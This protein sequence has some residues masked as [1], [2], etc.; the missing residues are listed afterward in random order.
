MRIAD[1]S[2]DGAGCLVTQFPVLGCGGAVVAGGAERGDLP[3][4]LLHVRRPTN[5]VIAAA[6]ALFLAACGS[7]TS[8]SV[9]SPS[10][11]E[12]CQT[13]VSGPPLSFGPSGGVGAITVSAARE[14]AWAASSQAAWIVLTSAADGQGDGSLSYRVV[15]NADPVLRRGVIW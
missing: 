6:A 15:E 12:R 2:R 9:T 11:T 8:T 10:W 13:T 5:A 1:V 4:S 14:C 7:S 3:A